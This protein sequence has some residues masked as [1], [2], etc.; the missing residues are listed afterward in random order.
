L[1]EY[2]RSNSYPIPVDALIGSQTAKGAISRP[3]A[4]L[5]QLLLFPGLLAIWACPKAS[6]TPFLPSVTVRASLNQV[7]WS[8][9]LRGR[10]SLVKGT[11]SQGTKGA[12]RRF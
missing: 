3:H 9:H 6:A 5:C 7:L 1:R 2:E 10:P 11:G 8:R 12:F 4:Q